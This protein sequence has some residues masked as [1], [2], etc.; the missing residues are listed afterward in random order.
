MKVGGEYFTADNWSQVTKVPKD[1]SDGYSGWLQYT[2]A[3]A[4]M[5]FGRYDSVNPSKDLKPALELT[6]DNLGVQWKPLKPLTAALAYKPAEVKGGTVSTGNGT[7]GST[8]AG[9]KG[10]YNEIG[11]WLSFDF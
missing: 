8:T 6:Y 9:S 7:I 1:K 11:L 4:W 5:L 2:A 10:T 3:P